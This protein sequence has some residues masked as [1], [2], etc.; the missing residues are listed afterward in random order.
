MGHVLTRILLGTEPISDRCARC[1]EEMLQELLTEICACGPVMVCQSCLTGWLLH[2]CRCRT[3]RVAVEALT[4]TADPCPILLGSAP[5]PNV[6]GNTT[7]N[8]AELAELAQLAEDVVNSKQD[9]W[10]CPAQQRADIESIEYSDSMWFED[11]Y[12]QALGDE[13]FE[14]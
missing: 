14:S 8:R 10:P 3:C 9:I 12:D 1:G 7:I 6:V 5:T 11:D 13:Y 2:A 4:A